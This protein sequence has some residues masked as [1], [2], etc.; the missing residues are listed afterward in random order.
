MQ[1]KH[2]ITT[3]SITYNDYDDNDNRVLLGNGIC[4]ELTA[5]RIHI[6]PV[7]N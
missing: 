7:I 1:T 6:L 5:H 2:F 4:T 3:S